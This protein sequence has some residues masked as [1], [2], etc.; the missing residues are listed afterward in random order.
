MDANLD[1]QTFAVAPAGPTSRHHSSS[2]PSTTTHGIFGPSSSAPPDSFVGTSTSLHHQCYTSSTSEPDASFPLVHAQDAYGS[3][4]AQPP[5]SSSSSSASSSPFNAPPPTANQYLTSPYLGGRWD[6]STASN[7]PQLRAGFPSEPPSPE[8]QHAL[9][10][11]ADP[12]PHPH[13]H[14]H[15]QHQLAPPAPSSSPEYWEYLGGR[16]GSVESS[17]T[18]ESI[19]GSGGGGPYATAASAWPETPATSSSLSSTPSSISLALPPLPPYAADAALATAGPSV[20][21]STGPIRSSRPRAATRHESQPR[22]EEAED[23]GEDSVDTQRE[24]KK[25]YAKSFR[26]VERRYFEDLRRR[27]FPNDPHAR[28]AECLERAIASVDELMGAR[29]REHRRAEEVRQLRRELDDA[30]R[31]VLDLQK[32]VGHLEPFPQ[33]YSAAHLNVNA[34]QW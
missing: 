17:A 26:D 20:P 21:S 13:Q 7:T 6:G 19:F 32:R 24:K 28:R 14:Q 12:H 8:T 25:Q 30:N 23:V 15:H 2:P 31:R 5:S 18:F 10:G 11:M 22:S 16:S 3:T 4:P 1:P 9:H 34:Q 27:L 29:E 33:S